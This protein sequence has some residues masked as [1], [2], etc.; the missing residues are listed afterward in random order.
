MQVLHGKHV[1]WQA[2]LDKVDP[3]GSFGIVGLNVGRE[4]KRDFVVRRSLP[5]SVQKSGM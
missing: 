2:V 4:A 5:G 1:D 3:G